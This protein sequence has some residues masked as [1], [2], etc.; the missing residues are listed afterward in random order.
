MTKLTSGIVMPVSA[1]FV[2]MTI[3]RTPGAATLNAAACSVDESTECSAMTQY[4]QAENTRTPAGHF[5]VPNIASSQTM[6]YCKP[7]CLVYYFV[8]KS[9]L[10]RKIWIKIFVTKLQYRIYV[11][12]LSILI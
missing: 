10:I 1:M 7:A 5:T 12:L 9:L 2:A 8:Y 3:L 6:S 4:L 11:Y